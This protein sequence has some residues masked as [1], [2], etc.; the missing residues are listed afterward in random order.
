MARPS[1]SARRMSLREMVDQL[2]GYSW[3]SEKG[4]QLEE[5]PAARRS[6]ES[7]LSTP[8]RSGLSARLTGKRESLLRYR[9]I[10]VGR[11]GGIRRQLW[12]KTFS[13]VEGEHAA[14][15][16][17]S[18]RNLASGIANLSSQACT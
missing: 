13:S 11:Q 10:R 3:A 17:R 15:T 14:V 12:R 16:G 6:T 2:R 9:R 18:S 8:P 4:I 7:I 5:C 1:I